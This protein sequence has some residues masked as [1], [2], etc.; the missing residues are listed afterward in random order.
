MDEL[1]R[2]WGVANA[3]LAGLPDGHTAELF[4]RIDAR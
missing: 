2:T 1:L 3:G 4:Q